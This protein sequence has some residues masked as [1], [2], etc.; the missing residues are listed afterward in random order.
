MPTNGS[1][2]YSVRPNGHNNPKAADKK[3]DEMIKSSPKDYKVYLARARYRHRFGLPG[4][5]A[6]SEKALNLAGDQ[7]EVFLEMAKIAET[8]VGKKV[9]AAQEEARKILAAGLKKIPTSTDLVQAL[10][11]LELR[12]RSLDAAVETLERGIKSADNKA[13][14]HFALAHVLAT[15]GD[16]G[17]LLVEIEEVKK[18]GFHGQIVQLLMGNYYVNHSQYKQALR[19]LAPLQSNPGWPAEYKTR[20]NALLARCYGALG[21]REMQQEAY[22]RVLNDNPNDLQAKLGLIERMIQQ[23]DVDEAIAQYRTFIKQLPMVSLRLVRLLIARIRQKPPLQRDWSELKS[24]LD[25]AEKAMP[26]LVE[27]VLTR[28]DLELAQDQ[29]SRARAVIEKGRSRF[30]KSVTLRCAQAALLGKDKQFEEANRV[31]DEARKE[32]GDNVEL[33]LQRARLAVAKGGPQVSA[34]LSDLSKKLESFS[35]GDRTTLLNGLAT[36]FMRLHDLP[37]AS[38]L[39]ARL[40]EQDPSDM[41]LRLKL[42]TLALEMGDNEQVENWIEQIQKIEGPE[43][44][45]AM[46]GQ[47]ATFD[48][49][50]RASH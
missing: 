45:L 38:R 47:A 26:E 28:A 24:L 15:R 2:R 30:P 20:V 39:W 10:A 17:K 7:P 36:E 42:F 8:E 22:Q 19:T 5:K 11:D 48:L 23:G 37:A 46:M 16:T 44:S 14:L 9:P 1:L 29:P 34:S 27:P 4:A 41:D 33:R 35:K 13:P 18:A 49:A 25:D 6:D 32:L 3:I 31:L 12:A 43:G 21:E 40:A 50:G